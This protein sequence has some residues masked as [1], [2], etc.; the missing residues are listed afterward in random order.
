M[1]TAL[2]LRR[3]SGHIGRVDGRTTSVTLGVAL[4]LIPKNANSTAG[5]VCGGRIL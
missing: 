4:D 3:Q 2:A 5:L 1:T